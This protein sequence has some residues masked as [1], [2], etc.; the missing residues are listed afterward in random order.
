MQ[1][2]MSSEPSIGLSQWGDAREV[3]I[4]LC[5]GSVLTE[6]SFFFNFQ[7]LFVGII[8]YETFVIFII[9]LY[10]YSEHLKKEK[11]FKKKITPFS[12]TTIFGTYFL[13]VCVLRVRIIIIV[14]KPSCLLVFI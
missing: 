5:S 10:L 2:G 6:K 11:H 3:H 1:A 4:L 12:P 7:F 13:P 14:C 9:K 8:L